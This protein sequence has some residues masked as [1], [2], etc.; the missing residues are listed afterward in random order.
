MFVQVVVL[1]ILVG[2]CFVEY[3]DEVE[4]GKLFGVVGDLL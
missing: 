2:V 3:W 1:V 4:V